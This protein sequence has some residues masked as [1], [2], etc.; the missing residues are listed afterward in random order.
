MN[1]TADTLP[2]AV[3]AIVKAAGRAI[4][5]SLIDNTPVDTGEARSN[6]L[7]SLGVP[8][9]GTIA[10]YTPYP[11]F[12]Q[13]NGRG[14]SETANAQGAK[15]RAEGAITARQP[16]QTLIIQNNVDHIGELNSG[17][18]KQAPALFVETSVMA[19]I[20]TLNGLRLNI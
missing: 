16:G 9:R 4:T 12:S 11:K 7:V 1:R 13:A 17:T 8:M 3:D 20:R 10:P 2:R 14:I 15:Q 5:F 6:W 19:G 18:S